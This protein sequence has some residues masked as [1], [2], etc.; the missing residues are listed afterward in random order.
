MD[1]TQVSCSTSPKSIEWTVQ[2]LEIINRGMHF[3]PPC[4]ELPKPYTLGETTVKENLLID[5]RMKKLPT[6]AQ[7]IDTLKQINNLAVLIEITDS[8]LVRNKALLEIIKLSD[9]ANTIEG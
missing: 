5:L 1:T 6:R 8:E 4:G 3:V 7:M 9:G 2:M